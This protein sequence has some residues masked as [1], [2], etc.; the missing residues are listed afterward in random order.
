MTDPRQEDRRRRGPVLTLVFAAL[1][2]GGLI[3]GGLLREPSPDGIAAV[4]ARAPDFTVELID[5]GAFT[6]SDRIVVDEPRAVVVNLWASWCIPC[7][8]EIP[9]ISDFADANPDVV[10]IGVAVQDSEQA[11][12]AF[13]AEINATYPLALGNEAFADAYRWLGLPTTFIIDGEGVVRRVHNG[14]VDAADLEEMTAG[15]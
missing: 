14:I 10:V 5:G 4:G 6:L 11:S 1:V 2:I 15:L 9:E 3:V 7:R 8:T 12:R 13:A